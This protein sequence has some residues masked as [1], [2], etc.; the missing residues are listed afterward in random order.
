MTDIYL[1]IYF[2]K[3]PSS[4]DVEKEMMK[5]HVKTQ[6]H[7]QKLYFTFKG[8]S[9]L[10]QMKLHLKFLLFMELIKLDLFYEC[11]DFFNFLIEL[12]NEY[13]QNQGFSYEE[14]IFGLNFFE[15]ILSNLENRSLNKKITG[16]LNFN[17]NYCFRFSFC[18]ESRENNGNFF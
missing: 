6:S 17:S 14:I 15:I 16:N 11:L 4:I 7:V 13:F 12:T 10:K 5:T 1:N 2:D 3:K 9:K 18:Q 8:L